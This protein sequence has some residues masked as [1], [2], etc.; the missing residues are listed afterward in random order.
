MTRDPDPDPP[1]PYRRRGLVLPDAVRVHEIVRDSEVH[2]VGE[3]VVDAEDIVGDWQRPSFDVTTQAVGLELDGE[4]V[5]YAEVFRGQRADAHVLPAHRGRGLGT[6]LA[7]WVV[8]EGR[9]QGGTTVGQPVL[10]GSDADR[11]LGSLGWRVR[12]TSWVLALEEGREIEPQPLPAGYAVRGLEP[13]EERLAYGVVER[14]FSEW[15]DRTPTA[16]EDWAAVTV[17]RPGFTRSMLRLVTAPDGAVVGAAVVVDSGAT[18]YVDQL[19]VERAHRGRGLARALLVDAFAGGRSRG[20]TRCELST[21]SRTGA[22]GLYE[23]V[24]MTVTSTWV[25]RGTDV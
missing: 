23:K 14:A 20:R 17:L 13:G 18:A 4:L 3:A 5:A 10:Q 6:W 9:R 24:G 12:W 8:A 11:L 1:A 22:L 15:P 2:D 25:N 16:Y 21:D 19:A 7:G